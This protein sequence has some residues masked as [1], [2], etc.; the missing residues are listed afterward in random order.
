MVSEFLKEL[1]GLV[2]IPSCAGTEEGGIS[3][4]VHLSRGK[5]EFL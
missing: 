1:E 2:S 3:Q 4:N 5:S